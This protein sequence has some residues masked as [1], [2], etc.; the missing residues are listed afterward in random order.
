MAPT[1]P[2]QSGGFFA[3]IASSISN[4]GRV[5]TKSINGLLGYEGLEVV[6]PEG[7]TED[8]E[9][10]V[11]K[12]RLKQELNF[13][14]EDLMMR[15]SVWMMINEAYCILCVHIYVMVVDKCNCPRIF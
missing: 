3:S 2:K 5:M 10:E 13:R 14:L 6:N 4:F 8:A 12:G 1:D 15:P 7:R 11:M 9:E